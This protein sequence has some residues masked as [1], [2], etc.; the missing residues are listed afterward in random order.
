MSE[1]TAE[2]DLET[3]AQLFK[4]LGHPARLLIV[5][6]IVEKPRHGEELAAIL[7]LKPATISHHLAQ[8]TIAGLLQAQKDQYYQM[9]SL[10]KGVLERPLRDIVS[11]PQPDLTAEVQED[12]YKQKVLKAFVKRG[13]LTQ[14]PAQLKKRQVI[15]EHLVQEFEP[16]RQYTEQEV[17]HTLLDFH[18]DVASL[19]RYMIETKLMQRER[20]I[21]WRTEGDGGR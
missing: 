3:R 12:A 21:Y 19:R 15:L 18:E 2:K 10:V 13:R 11:L 5:N 7:H 14:I 16:G 9:Y 17:N 20:G 1:T 4:A 6:L 8:L